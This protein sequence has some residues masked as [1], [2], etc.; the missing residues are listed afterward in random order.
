MYFL[1]IV[2]VWGVLSKVPE[3]MPRFSSAQSFFISTADLFFVYII[4]FH[5][6]NMFVWYVLLHIDWIH[7]NIHTDVKVHESTDNNI[8]SPKSFF[9]CSTL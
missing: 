8:K 4:T 3:S 1:F 7:E 6:R 5:D 9:A 2:F